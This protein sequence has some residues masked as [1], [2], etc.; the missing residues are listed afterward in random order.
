MPKVA[1]SIPILL[2]GLHFHT[3][4]TQNKAAY[5]TRK[6]KCS[7]LYFQELWLLAARISGMANDY[8]AVMCTG[9][10]GFDSCAILT[11]RPY[12]GYAILW[13]SNITAGVEIIETGGRRFCPAK[14]KGN[15]WELMITNVYLPHES[16]ADTEDF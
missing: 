1:L 7:V 11:E 6:S 10:N 3:Y 16:D 14:F 9:I 15:D 5:N 8:K 2:N 4:C 12:G 13:H